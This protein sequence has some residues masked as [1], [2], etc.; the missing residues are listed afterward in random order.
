MG[1]EKQQ[2][3]SK[4]QSQHRQQSASQDTE[5]LFQQ[6]I[7]SGQT[8]SIGQRISRI[9]NIPSIAAHAGML[10]GAS[11]KQQSANRQ[12]LLQLQRQHGNR[13]VQQVVQAGQQNQPVIQTK[14]TLGAVGDKYEQEADRVAKQ[15]VN[16]I[17]STNQEPVQRMKPEDEELAQMKP[18]IQRIAVGEATEV[19]PS[20]EDAIQGARGRG[21][22]LAK[23]VRVPMEQAFGADFSRVRIHAD[24]QSHQLNQSIQARAFTTGQDVFFR[25]G[26]YNPGSWGGQELIAHELTH[27]VQQNGRSESSYHLA[28]MPTVQR[29]KYRANSPPFNKTASDKNVDISTL[30]MAKALDVLAKLKLAQANSKDN[31]DIYKFDPNDEN[32]LNLQI[33]QRLG[34]EVNEIKTALASDDAE[35]SKRKISMTA[36]QQ[37]ELID[38]VA[39][40]AGITGF[41]GWV[42]EV[43]TKNNSEQR[44]DQ[45]NEL[46]EAI[47][48]YLESRVP[49]DVSEKF[50]PGTV[51]GHTA[52]LTMTGKQVEV[53]TVR[54]PIN[55]AGE[56][57]QQI[58]AGVSKFDSAQFEENEVT[59]F[60]SYDSKFINGIEV[61]KSQKPKN[62]VQ[63]TRVDPSNNTVSVKIE[64]HTDPNSVTVQN[65]K[66]RGTIGSELIKNPLK[67]K[68]PGKDKVR[69]INIM[70]ENGQSFRLKR[71]N[72]GSG[73]A[74]TEENI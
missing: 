28:K 31:E 65:T 71:T 54:A 58:R 34:I 59:V 6:R 29:L 32:N 70:L 24:A 7:G 23:N 2:K 39:Q 3:A 21:Q 27:V 69:Y 4:N 46:R 11:A 48:Q 63:I 9:S 5:L 66:N 68:I 42:A 60:A 20:I 45:I 62:I 72:S 12:L 15:V 74:W 36:S 51:G 22:P 41:N 18:D 38:N 73:T 16:S 43:A 35:R 57:S 49:V 64:D 55:K 17:S 52:D 1:K 40:E 67:Q 47:R 37:Q 61:V 14:L 26:E 8:N 19:D 10:N 53:K 25:Q 33:Q 50:V 13:Y 56:L 30:T 44:Q